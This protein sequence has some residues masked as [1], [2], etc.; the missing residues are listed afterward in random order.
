MDYSVLEDIIF[1]ASEV[2]KRTF[3]IIIDFATEIDFDNIQCVC[4]DN[5]KNHQVIRNMLQNSNW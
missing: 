1:L 2:H 5:E 3:E 4:G